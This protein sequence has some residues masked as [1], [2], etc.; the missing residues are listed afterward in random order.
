MDHMHC[1]SETENRNEIKKIF[2]YMQYINKYMRKYV[3]VFE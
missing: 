1:F 2:E 3:C